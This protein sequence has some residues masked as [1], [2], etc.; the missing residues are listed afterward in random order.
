ME[1]TASR[2]LDNRLLDL[3]HVV[4]DLDGTVYLDHELFSWTSSFLN[5]LRCLGLDYT[6]L[7]NNSSH[8]A[9]AYLEKLRGLGLIARRSQLRT[10]TDATID[11]LRDNWPAVRCLCVLGTSG[12]REDFSLAGFDLWTPEN[13][14]EP[15][16]VVVGFDTQLSYPKLCAAAY[17]IRRHKPYVATHPDRWCPTRKPTVLVDCG[18]LIACLKAATGKEP[19]AILGKPDPRM[20]QGVFARHR[21]R[22]F[23]VLIV[24]DRLYTDVAMAR[25]VGAMSALVLSGETTAEQVQCADF[26]PDLVVAHLGEL[27]RLIRQVHSPGGD[28][29]GLAGNDQFSLWRKSRI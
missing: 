28:T 20:L 4:L 25:A 7:T 12:L 1:P 2:G 21:C 24:G 14:P 3:K 15:D 9:R 5:T 6:F 11:F 18:S 27:E 8:S 22:P 29:L 16:G 10:S 26:K 13:R 17:W 19:D 23:Q